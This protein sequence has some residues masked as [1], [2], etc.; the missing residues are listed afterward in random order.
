MG[1]TVHSDFPYHEAFP[2][3]C[4]LCQMCAQEGEVLAGQKPKVFCRRMT[5]TEQE[6]PFVSVKDPVCAAEAGPPDPSTG[7]QGDLRA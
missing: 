5:R 6:S 7:G 3:N 2:E 1:R 4:G